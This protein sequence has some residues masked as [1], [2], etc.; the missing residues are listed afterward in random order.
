[1]T[2]RRIRAEPVKRWT[3]DEDA[4]IRARYANER[5]ADLVEALPGRAVLSICR[6]AK[7]LGIGKSEAFMKSSASGRLDGV[8]GAATRFAKGH[9]PWTAGQK[10]Y[11]PG[12]RAPETQFRKGAMPHNHVPVGTKRKATIG[13]WKVKVA[14]PD[15]WRFVHR[16]NWEEAHGPIPRGKVLRFKDGN[17]DNCDLSNLELVTRREIMAR[18]T[19]HNLPAPLPQLVMLRAAVVRKINRRRR[20]PA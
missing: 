17:Q 16:M 8:R 12:G 3:P 10:G 9:V 2:K 1:M 14:E 18:N 7:M 15:E 19:L 5:T 4:V 20:Q 6:R 13:Q 11:K